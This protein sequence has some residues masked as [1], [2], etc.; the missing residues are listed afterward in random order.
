MSKHCTCK[1]SPE[2]EEC[3]EWIFTFADLVML[4]MGFFVMLWALKPPAGKD[5]KDA[6]AEEQWL[7]TVGSIRQGFG[8]EPNPQSADPVD[9]AI[10]R[11]KSHNGPRQG[12]ENEQ[13]RDSAVGTDH[14]TTT[15]RNG[16]QSSVGG[17]LLFDAGD[18]KLKPDVT[19]VLDGIAEK[20]RGHYN[21]VMIKGHASLD[22]QADV[23]TP[24]ERMNLSIRRAEAVAT[25]LIAHGVQPE[26][27]RVQ[28]CSTF[29]PVKQRDY[30]PNAQAENR[31]VEV[32]VTSTLIE[33]RQDTSAPTSSAP[34]HLPSAS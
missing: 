27:L 26:T 5:V 17:R 13:P 31:R 19:H 28:G 20:I 4:M 6:P 9:K 7:V 18:A 33:E 34:M 16:R 22:D 2:C 15:I 1:K 29:E 32:E 12:A 23:Q 3:P 8:Y 30:N 25:Y 14:L 10:I 11:H 21:I 24:S